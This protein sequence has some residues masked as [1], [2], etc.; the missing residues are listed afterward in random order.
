MHKTCS[1][2]IL[3]VFCGA[4]MFALPAIAQTTAAGQSTMVA[5]AVETATAI[6]TQVVDTHAVP[7]LDSRMCIR[8]T[9]SHIPPP[10]GQC[11]P[12]AGNSYTQQDLQRTGA[13]DMGRAL[14]MLDPSVQVH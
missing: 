10:K 2:T 5:P 11:L 14:Q 13:I 1:G 9:G 6:G 12:V 7:P 8:E 3:A 4:A